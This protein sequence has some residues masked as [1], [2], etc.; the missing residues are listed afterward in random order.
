MW[1]RAVAVWLAGSRIHVELTVQLEIAIEQVVGY[2]V[3]ASENAQWRGVSSIVDR[4]DRDDMSCVPV[5]GHRIDH[6]GASHG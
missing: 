6:V 4:G 1:A 2:A 3:L 5:V